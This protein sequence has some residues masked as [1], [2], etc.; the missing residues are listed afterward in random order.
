[1]ASDSS[2]P[3]I[4]R[5]TSYL[6]RLD[7]I[8]PTQFSSLWSDHGALAAPFFRYHNILGYTQTHLTAPAVATLAAS[9]PMK[10]LEFD[11]MVDLHFDSQTCSL[12]NPANDKHTEEQK[13]STRRYFEEVILKDEKR[14]WDRTGKGNVKGSVG[15]E[16]GITRVVGVERKVMVDGRIAIEILKDV[17]EKWE[18]YNTG[19]E[20]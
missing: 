6:R 5:Y 7:T 19:V 8:T 18:S 17:K 16:E 14:F 2:A 1:M 11:G 13:K 3:Q 20:I 9:L 4:L 15:W 10:M 12:F